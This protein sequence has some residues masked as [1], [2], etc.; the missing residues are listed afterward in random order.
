[1]YKNNKMLLL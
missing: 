1:M